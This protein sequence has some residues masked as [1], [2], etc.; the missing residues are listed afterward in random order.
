MSCQ[1][2]D[3]V[4]PESVH[5]RG[6]RI[7]TVMILVG[8]YIGAKYLTYVLYN[9]PLEEDATII[10]PILQIRKLKLREVKLPKIRQ[11]TSGRAGTRVN[12]M[13]VDSTLLLFCITSLYPNLPFVLLKRQA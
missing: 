3:P 11:L 2:Q 5:G 7:M 12:G 1:I 13:P 6:A 10:I 4:L 8:S 9:N